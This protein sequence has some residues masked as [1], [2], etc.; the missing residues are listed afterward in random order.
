MTTPSVDEFKVFLDVFSRLIEFEKSH[1]LRCGW[2]CF[3]ENSEKLPIPEVVKVQSWL[4]E[5]SN[6]LPT[7]TISMEEFVQ[8]YQQS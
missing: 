4:Q 1:R 7:P 3:D 6:P 8:H 5:W 2:G